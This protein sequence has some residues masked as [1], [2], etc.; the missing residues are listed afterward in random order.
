MPENPLNIRA[1]IEVDGPADAVM[2]WLGNLPGATGP[3]AGG[4]VVPAISMR[5]GMDAD[6]AKALVRQISPRAR[7]VLFEI[8]SRTPEASFEDVQDSLDIDGVQL[9]GIMASF[10]FAERRG[11]PRPFVVDRSRRVYKIDPDA[12]RTFLSVLRDYR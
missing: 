2:A 12:A 4:A 11:V 5:G 10:G 3:T 7:E 8:A 9:G 1:T 6:Y